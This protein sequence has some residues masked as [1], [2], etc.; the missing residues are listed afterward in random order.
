MCTWDEGQAPLIMTQELE[1][2]CVLLYLLLYV[3][4]LSI[5]ICE[6][7]ARL[8]ADSSIPNV[9]S[10]AVKELHH[11]NSWRILTGSQEPNDSR[12]VARSGNLGEKGLFI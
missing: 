3:L 9:L 11:V 10:Q 8:A 7:C 5:L 12:V 6:A 1:L 2:K 4:R